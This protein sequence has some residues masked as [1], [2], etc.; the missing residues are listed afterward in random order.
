M[1]KRHA[2]LLLPAIANLL[3]MHYSFYYTDLLEWTLKCSMVVNLFS[4][5]FDVFILLFFFSLITNGRVKTTQLLTF[6][7]TLLWSFVNVF[8]GRF[9]YHYMSLSAIGAA[10]GLQDSFVIDSILTGFRWSDLFYVLSIAGFILLYIK[11]PKL[12]VSLRT[13][14]GLLIVPLCSL[15]LAIAAYSAYHF[16]HPEFRGNWELY[17]LRLQELLYDANRGGTPNLSRFHIGSVRIV[18]YELADMCLKKELTPE[19]RTE[20]RNYY[21]DKSMRVSHHERNPEIRN[22]VF[23]LLES[24][25][26]DPI[27]KQID[28]KEVTPFLNSLKRDSA[29][30]YNGCVLSDITCG[31]SGDGQFIY[32]N[33]LLPLQ[34]KM[35]VGQVKDNSL[36]ALPKLL[37]EQLDIKHTEIVFPTAPNL[38]QQSDMNRAYGISTAYSLEDIT[39]GKT[40]R[41]NDQMIFD[42]A[43][44]TLNPSNQPFFSLILSISGHEPYSEAVGDFV[45][46]DS[47]YPQEYLNYLS[48]CHFTDLQVQ[49]YVEALKKQNL[50]DNTLIII[51]A[52]HFAHVDAMG[53]VGK[54]KS[55]I[56]LFVIHGNIDNEQ[57]W[58]GEMHQLDVYT[59]LLDVL[60]IDSEWRGL[61]HTVLLP[62]YQNSVDS[63]AYELSRLIIEGDYFGNH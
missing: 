2:L 53:M 3:Y 30:F 34:Q 44:Q 39:R 48:T 51:T 16:M 28:G 49:K 11:T 25:L 17:G 59:T 22:V 27:D 42:F 8:Y 50:Y 35:T 41:I 43:A 31:E 18:M 60:G 58:H 45:F 13:T 32:M 33:G 62:H 15:L 29:V 14:L 10:G 37:T 26:S 12:K 47:Q 54:V 36:P 6:V 20:I 55:D 61:G 38:W 7:I 40:G 57:A 56:P 21:Q 23:I 63:H 5:F 1:K 24:M 19:E 52:D 46:K 4:V 9:F